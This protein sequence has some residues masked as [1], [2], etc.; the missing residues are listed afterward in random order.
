[1]K[2]SEAALLKSGFSHADLQKIKNNVDSYG[3][4]LGE[5]IH[6]LANRFRIVLWVFFRLYGCIYLGN[7]FK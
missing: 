3:G 4:S 6:D 1:M 7:S 2:V 5:S